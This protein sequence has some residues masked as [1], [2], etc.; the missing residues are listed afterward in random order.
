MRKKQIIVLI[1]VFAFIN[2]GII[3]LAFFARA[4][5]NS[6]VFPLEKM[7]LMDLTHENFAK[8][9]ATVPTGSSGS[10]QP[11][12]VGDTE[13]ISVSDDWIGE[14]YDETFIVVEEGPH[15]LILITQDAFDSFDGEYYYFDNPYGTWGFYEHPISAAQLEY[16][17]NEFDNTIYPTVTTN[18]GAPLPRGEEGQKVWIVIFNIKDQAYYDEDAP[19]YTAGYFSPSTNIEE[20]K[21]IIHIDTYDWSNR[22]GPGELPH[23]AYLYE[24]A[25]A[26]EFEHLVH[27]DI[28]FDESLCPL[29]IWLY[30]YSI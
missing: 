22:I 20:D 3:S 29:Y 18:Y 23:R 14:M 11:A 27:Y 25:I 30:G 13:V 5:S 1:M 10:T 24:G 2:V 21:N 7:A 12:G 26:H 15:C 6:G 28:D 9:E 16:M 19:W 8:R 17:K 4:G